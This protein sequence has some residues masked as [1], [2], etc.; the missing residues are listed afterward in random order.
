M[1][2]IVTAFREGTT[3]NGKPYG[4]IKIEDFT[5]SG[6]IPLFG[7]DYFNFSKYA[8]P[9]IY[10]LIH[11]RME[12]S[13]W[14]PTKMDFR[15]LSV[16]LMQDKKDQ[17]IEKIC[18]TVPIHDL[19]EPTLNELSTLIKNNPGN[20]LLYFRVVDGEHNVSL[21]LF[22]HGTKLNVTRELVDFLKENDNIDFKING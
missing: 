10:L 21:N 6:E 4:I 2:G 16:D 1:G 8:K 14:N 5:G 3:K 7:P 17:L 13:K 22:A 12:P 9:G 15:I 18:I 20:S 19:D 11:A